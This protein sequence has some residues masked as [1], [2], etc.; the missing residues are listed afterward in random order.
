MFEKQVLSK[1]F[2]SKNRKLQLTGHA[3]RNT[4]RIQVRTLL[5]ERPHERS[6]GGKRITLRRVG[7]EIVRMRCGW[8]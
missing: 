6:K 3:T 8:N 5:V 1:I 2:V 7:K 4:Y